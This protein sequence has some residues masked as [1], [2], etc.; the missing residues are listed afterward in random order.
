MGPVDGGW[1]PILSQ[2]LRSS[3]DLV[4]ATTK[5]DSN[6]VQSVRMNHNEIRMTGLGIGA[7][8]VKMADLYSQTYL[9]ER[10]AI[11]EVP[12]PFLQDEIHLS[13]QKIDSL[14]KKY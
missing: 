4:F 14:L 13:D 6:T 7:A 11:E 8:Q 9:L 3:R 1:I 10:Y 5:V 2:E 12:V